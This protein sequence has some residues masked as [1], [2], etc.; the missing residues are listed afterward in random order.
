MNAKIIVPGRPVPKARPRPANNRRG[1]I[2]PART[3]NYQRAVG[4][5]AKRHFSAPLT[6]QIKVSIILYFRGGRVGDIDNYQK[7]I[8]DGLNGI[9]FEDDRQVQKVICELVI[10]NMDER[11]E[12]EIEE[13]AG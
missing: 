3:M 7:S 9:A 13:V 10:T 11:A 6:G 2:I 5:A 4:W 12:I 1:F 8:L